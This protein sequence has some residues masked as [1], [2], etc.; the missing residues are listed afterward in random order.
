MVGTSTFSLTAV[1]HLGGYSC[2]FLGWEG[3]ERG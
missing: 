2:L 1:S 3:G